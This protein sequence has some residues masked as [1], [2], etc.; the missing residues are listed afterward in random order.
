MASQLDELDAI[1]AGQ[2]AP[3]TSTVSAPA[4]MNLQPEKLPTKAGNFIPAG[5]TRVDR[6]NN[7]IAVI[8]S[9]QFTKPL[10]AAGIEYAKGDPFPTAE[11]GSKY[12]TM[13]FNTPEDG[14]KAS[15]IIL[16][17]TPAFQNWYHN[18]SGL[19]AASKFGIRTQEDFAALP[20]D[21]QVEAIKLISVG[22]GSKTFPKL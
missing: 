7:P 20:P 6:H 8:Y 3:K 13:K 1:I 11:G 12:F 10:D 22:E 16:S 19:S 14:I 4:Q 18:K 21:K 5:G 9:D 2:S 17:K 15:Q